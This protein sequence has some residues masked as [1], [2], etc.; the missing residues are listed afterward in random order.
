M[1]QAL[2]ILLGQPALDVQRI[3]CV[4]CARRG[5]RREASQGLSDSNGPMRKAAESEARIIETPAP[6][7]NQHSGASLGDPEL[8]RVDT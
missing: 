4:H 7:I 3:F 2:T 1:L 6:S 5:S 8:D